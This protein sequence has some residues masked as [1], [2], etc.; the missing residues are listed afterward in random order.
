MQGSGRSSSGY[1]A[2]V[3]PEPPGDLLLFALS[4]IVLSA[5][6]IIWTRFGV[7][8]AFM[9]VLPLLALRVVA[10][11]S[12]GRRL[13]RPARLTLTDE[14]L[15]FAL[16]SGRPIVVQPMRGTFVLHAFALLILSSPD[17]RGTW[18]VVRREKQAPEQWRRFLVLW[19]QVASRVVRR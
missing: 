6:F 16:V 7:A 15:W 5:T 4:V 12:A 14:G 18:V 11:I 9:A 10:G 19:C 1:A 3:I 2:I 8:A 13:A 17:G